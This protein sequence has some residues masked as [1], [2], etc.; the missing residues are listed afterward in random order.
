[1]LLNSVVL[2]PMFVKLFL[3]L[4]CRCINHMQSFWNRWNNIVVWLSVRGVNCRTSACSANG[5][6]FNLSNFNFLNSNSIIRM[7]QIISHK[8][9]LKIL[10]VHIYRD[11]REKTH[12]RDSNPRYGWRLLSG[13]YLSGICNSPID[14]L[15]SAGSKYPGGIKELSS[16]LFIWP[17]AISPRTCAFNRV[18]VLLLHLLP[19]HCQDWLIPG[20]VFIPPSTTVF[21]YLKRCSLWQA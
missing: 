7:R 9:N 2:E 13:N 11:F 18:G 6:E 4:I 21:S 14:H 19:L 16:K 15:A 17:P 3:M 5:I 12:F 1:M 20:T 10:Q 8:F